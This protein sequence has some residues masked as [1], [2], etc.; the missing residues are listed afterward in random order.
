[1]ALGG[2][3]DV[4]DEPYDLDVGERG[5]DGKVVSPDEMWQNFLNSRFAKMTPL[6]T[7]QPFTLY[8]AHGIS[9]T[10]RIDDL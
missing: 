4:F 10:G 9:V 1:M 2:A 3:G 5:G 7:E 6:M 8:L